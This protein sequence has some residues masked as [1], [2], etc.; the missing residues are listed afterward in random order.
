MVMVCCDVEL[1]A[2]APVVPAGPERIELR[3]GGT[4]AGDLDL[5]A[6]AAC[7]IAV[8]DHVRVDPPFRRRGLATRLVRAALSARPG[9]RWSTSVLGGTDEARGFW[10]AL[11]EWPGTTGIPEE[12]AHMH[13]AA[14]HSP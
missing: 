5:R 1:V 10:S 7:R 6:C 14:W 11:T 13:E 3:L 9:Y 12:C 8:V 4:A 2:V